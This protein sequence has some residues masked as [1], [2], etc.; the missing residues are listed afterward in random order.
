MCLN[1]FQQLEKSAS[2]NYKRSADRE[3]KGIKLLDEMQKKQ[4]KELIDLASKQG[5]ENSA[6]LIR[7]YESQSRLYCI[8]QLS[9][10]EPDNPE[11]RRDDMFFGGLPFTSLKWPWPIDLNKNR[12][13][14]IAQLDLDI[15]GNKLKRQLGSGILQVWGEYLHHV[16]RDFLKNYKEQ[17][18]SQ[19]FSLCFSREFRIHFRVIPREDLLDEVTLENL[20][21]VMSDGDKLFAKYADMAGTSGN[22]SRITWQ[23]AR[24][25]YYPSF[26]EFFTSS[27]R[28]PADSDFGSWRGVLEDEPRL[29]DKLKIMNVT[30]SN[31]PWF[32]VDPACIL[33]GYPPTL[34]HHDIEYHANILLLFR[35][36][37]DFAVTFKN[38]RRGGIEFSL[39]S[40]YDSLD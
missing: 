20:T 39:E 30:T 2:K 40:H 35:N 19:D 38:D 9:G 31:T 15:A 13:Y 25:M 21:G 27:R 1:Y 8:P 32:C 29:D 14:P 16:P 24:T 11:H 3:L 28:G 17:D 23:T 34:Y 7:D 5:S 36:R 33:G 37:G 22:H 26:Y 18:N 4:S 12:L 10:F 6:N